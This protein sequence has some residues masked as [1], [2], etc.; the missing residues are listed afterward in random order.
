MD[1]RKP[2]SKTTAFPTWQSF[3]DEVEFVWRNARE[4]NE[5]DSEIV[6]FAGVLEA[7]DCKNQVFRG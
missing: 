7:S 4:F 6:V 5:D 1:G 3:E 2:F